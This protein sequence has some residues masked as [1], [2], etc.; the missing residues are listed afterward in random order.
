MARLDFRHHTSALRH[1]VIPT[2]ELFASA[3]SYNIKARIPQYSYSNT[4]VMFPT[5]K[6][7]SSSLGRATAAQR[8]AWAKSIIQTADQTFLNEKAKGYQASRLADL[9]IIAEND[10]AELRL[11]TA[12]KCPPYSISD[13]NSQ[14]PA[15]YRIPPSTI[16]DVHG[17]ECKSRAER[18]AVASLVYQ[19][20][21]DK[22]PFAD[23]NES[24]VQQNF[25]NGIYPEET[26]EF[27]FD[28][29]L[30]MMSLWSQEFAQER[31]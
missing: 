13:F 1:T 8:I 29:A 3:S 28:I 17:D 18:F 25:E 31:K 24:I 5:C 26:K 10:T 15:R 20:M 23:L 27:P 11:S 30:A 19:V 6:V 16:P 9:A 22:P 21:A 14:Y 4:F 2:K 12:L 7:V